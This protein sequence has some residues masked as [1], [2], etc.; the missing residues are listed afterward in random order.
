MLHFSP[1]DKFFLIWIIFRT[2]KEE[3]FYWKPLKTGW[4]GFVRRGAV[5]S[6]GGVL[7]AFGKPWRRDRN[8]GTLPTEPR[9]KVSKRGELN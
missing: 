7:V 3:P 8:R 2:A 1:G 4:N 6:A 9:F 5:R